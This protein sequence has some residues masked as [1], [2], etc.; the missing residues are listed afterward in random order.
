[1][2][3]ET[4]SRPPTT[5]AVRS[6]RAPSPRA[7]IGWLVGG[8][9]VTFVVSWLGTTVIGLHHDVFYLVYFTAALGYIGWFA[10]RSRLATGELLRRNLWWSLGIGALV[11]AAAVRQVMDQVGTSHPKGGFFVFELVWRGVVYGTVDALTLVVFPTLVAYLVLRGNR[12]GLPRK[13]AFAGLVLLLSLLVSA[14]YHLGYSTYRGSE[15]TKPL[16]GTALMTV[17]ALLTGNPLGAVVAHASVHTSAV[18]HQYYGGDG[19][20]HYLPPELSAS[21]PDRPGGTAA[22]AVAAGW[23]ALGGVVL[24]FG[25]RRISELLRLR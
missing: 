5:S 23:V 13:A 9:A 6:D 25:R 18:V 3:L 1:M 8:A 20:N 19:T 22:L 17:P 21:Y 16:T 15:M 4:L 10:A 12:K 11:A 2:T 24:A 14:S 7:A